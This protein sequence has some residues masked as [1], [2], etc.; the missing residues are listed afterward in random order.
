MGVESGEAITS[1][2]A[3]GD[4]TGET[5]DERPKLGG[6]SWAGLIV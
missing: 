3:D 1:I 4:G 5:G 2:T 6:E